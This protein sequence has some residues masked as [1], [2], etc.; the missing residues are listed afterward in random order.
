M[1]MTGN[2]PKEIV[3]AGTCWLT[4]LAVSSKAYSAEPM[5]SV[6]EMCI[7]A[8]QTMEIC[9]CASDVLLCKI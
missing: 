6:T 2:W 5:D 4:V 7:D 9:I 8:G 1:H 3:I